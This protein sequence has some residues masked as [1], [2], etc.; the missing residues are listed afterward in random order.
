MSFQGGRSRASATVS[1]PPPEDIQEVSEG[2][3]A[4][5]GRGRS[6]CRPPDKEAAV[7]AHGLDPSGQ[8]NLAHPKGM[9]VD[10]PGTT[11]ILEASQGEYFS[12][13]RGGFA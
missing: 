8:A 7:V 9:E 5:S 10:Q 12:P 2:L 3:A 13:L 1:S 6:P 4:G 11:G